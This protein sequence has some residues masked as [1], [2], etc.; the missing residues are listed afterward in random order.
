M[1]IMTKILD[2]ILKIN[3]KTLALIAII[4][5][6]FTLILFPFIDTNFFYPNRIKSRIDILQKITELDMDKINRDED[7]AKEYENIV[8]EVNRS[9]SNYVNKVFN[10]KSD[11][12]IGKI[13]SG[14]FLWW[15]LGI[16]F[17]FSYKD[18]KNGKYWITKIA[19]FIVC[20]S[21]GGISGFICSLIP[22][23]F[24]IWFN[25]TMN[26]ILACLLMFLIFYKSI[27]NKQ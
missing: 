3:K 19:G 7:L 8:K 16:I 15:L 27:S 18:N 14:G 21:I 20:L 6:V 5:S 23:I 4:I 22:T 24:N 12:K 25:Y 10:N 11:H 2:K 26:F 1:D 17:L 9:D 13:I